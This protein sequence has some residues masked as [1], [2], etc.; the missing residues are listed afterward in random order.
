MKVDFDYP[1]CVP[2]HILRRVLIEQRYDYDEVFFQNSFVGLLG[3]VFDTKVSIER[4]EILSG[5]VRRDIS[6]VND[7]TS[8]RWFGAGAVFRKRVYCQAGTDLT[9]PCAFEAEVTMFRMATIQWAGGRSKRIVVGSGAR[10]DMQALFGCYL[11]QGSLTALGN[12]DLY[13][14]DFEF[15]CT[16]ESCIVAETGEFRVV[17]P[18]QTTQIRG[19]AT[20]INSVGVFARWGGRVIWLNSDITLTG[21]TPGVDLA[22]ETQA[23]PR[24]FITS[25]QGFGEPNGTLIGRA[26]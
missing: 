9:G 12:I 22:T 21:G 23:H 13:A 19:G 16:N 25:G 5:Y 3:V 4:S 11:I 6:L 18:P 26:G 8:Y 24:L 14:G 20:G 2:G 10:L 7:G 1:F 17:A 15:R